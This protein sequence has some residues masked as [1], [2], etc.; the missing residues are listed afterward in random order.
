MAFCRVLNEGK[1]GE[2]I[3]GQFAFLSKQ[4]RTLT[5][6]NPTNRGGTQLSHSPQM[7][8]ASGGLL[9]LES[10]MAAASTN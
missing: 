9:I 4:Y 3:Q 2:L 8:Y 7:I 1:D 5:C 10:C 6:H